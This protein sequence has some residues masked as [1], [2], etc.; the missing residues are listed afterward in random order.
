MNRH[1]W[2]YR[3][4]ADVDWLNDFIDDIEDYFKSL[5]TEF[6]EEPGVVS[7][8]VVSER[9][10]GQNFSVDVS[11]GSAYDSAGQRIYNSATTNVP[12][13]TDALG[14][15]VECTGGGNERIV[16]VYA[17]YN[18]DNTDPAVDGN[19][20]TVQ[21]V[22]TETVSFELRQGAIAAAGAAVAA[23]NPNDGGVLLANVTIATGDLTISTS[24]CNNAVKDR[25]YLYP[26]SLEN[27]NQL[28]IYSTHPV[29][30]SG[31][32]VQASAAI[33][34]HCKDSDGNIK[35]GTIAAG[36]LALSDGQCLVV[37]LDRSNTGITYGSIAYASLAAGS[38]SIV[39]ESS[40]GVTNS[41]HRDDV[42]L[43][44]RRTVAGGSDLYGVGFEQL[45]MPWCGQI[46]FD[47]ESFY[48]G[49]L[50]GSP[51]APPPLT[52]GAYNLGISL[53]AG[54]CK[55]VGA[56]GTD[57]SEYN[58]G[59]VVMASNTPGRLV[60]LRVTSANHFFEDD[61]GASDIIGEEFGTTA[62]VAWGND[63]PF[64]IHAVNRNDTEA[65]VAFAH[66]PDPRAYI[67]ADTANIGYHGTPMG[68][69][70]DTGFFFWT[71][72]N[73]T[74]THNQ[75]PCYRIGGI[76][77]RKTAA[78]DWTVQ[79]LNVNDG[80]GIRRDPF[81]G[82]A[83]SFVDNQMGASPSCWLLPNGGTAPVFS[84]N[85]YAYCIKPNGDVMVDIVLDGDGGT[86]G[87]G[88]VQAKVAL[89]YKRAINT[90]VAA[91]VVR[92]NSSVNGDETGLIVT[93][94]N[95]ASF[96]IRAMATPSATWPLSNFGNGARSILCNFTYRAFE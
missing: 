81:F 13:T 16:S 78:D 94:A 30:F 29:Y 44:R 56:S 71:A 95:V 3:F 60:R 34:I 28:R 11:S 36:T 85:Q 92:L 42:I 87:A 2:Y 39:A 21:T 57:L 24:N 10:A 9:G 26:R 46:A 47:H 76:R 77:M 32:G 12:F 73:V 19:G 91:G 62:G 70:S 69:P 38:Y 67:S 68:T 27:D 15:T 64:F 96:D 54:T 43:F 84:A 51:S 31:T 72:T 52:M 79:T 1:Y 58:V 18:V 8:M 49:K 75:K 40:I 61:N 23:A 55:I 41:I 88:A 20:A 37:R 53:N 5:V 7:G 90:N 89:P 17:Y 66:S 48:L 6:S 22:G 82:K 45:E 93:A 14:A 63:R 25:F 4:L 80:D 83:F 33:N 74:A 50:T 65:G 59:W 35:T 86:D